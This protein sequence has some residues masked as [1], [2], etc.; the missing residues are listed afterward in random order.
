MSIFTLFCLRISSYVYIK[1]NFKYVNFKT[2]D[3]TKTSLPINNF[4]II[5]FRRLIFIEFTKTYNFKSYFK[6]SLY[7]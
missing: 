4:C 5:K 3:N 2:F 7:N 6:D 1:E